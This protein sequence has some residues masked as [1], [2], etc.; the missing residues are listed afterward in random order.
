MANNLI[1]LAICDQWRMEQVNEDC[2][3]H[4]EPAIYA[5]AANFWLFAIHESYYSDSALQYQDGSLREKM[6]AK[7]SQ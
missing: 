2:F 6:G 4:R 5:A 7:T 1:F 3:A